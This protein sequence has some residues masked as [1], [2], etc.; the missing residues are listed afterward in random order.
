[1]TTD[2]MGP[3]LERLQ[4]EDDATVMEVII[5]TTIMTNLTDGKTSGEF[6]KEVSGA[7]YEVWS[8]RFS[9]KSSEGLMKLVMQQA[10][11]IADKV[12]EDFER[13]T[14]AMVQGASASA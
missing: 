6:A 2:I 10:G 5:L 13:F 7:A 14:H 4:E 12:Q 1:M 11:A 9:D 3:I 8:R